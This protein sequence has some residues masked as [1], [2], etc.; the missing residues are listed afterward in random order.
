MINDKPAKVIGELF[1]SLL[2]RYQ[3]GLEKSMR[4]SDFIFNSIQLSYH[5]CYKI[6]LNEVEYI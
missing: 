2:F 1:Q 6:N 3:I 5:E 4:G